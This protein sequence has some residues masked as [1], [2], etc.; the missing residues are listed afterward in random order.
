MS[1]DWNFGD[2]V[3]NI[4]IMF[5]PKRQIFI[6]TP[7][8]TTKTAFLLPNYQQRHNVYLLIV[9]YPSLIHYLLT[10]SCG[11]GQLSFFS[12]F[13]PNIFGP[14]IS[15]N[16]TARFQAEIAEFFKS[17]EEKVCFAYGSSITAREIGKRFS[18]SHSP[19]NCLPHSPPEVYR[20]CVEVKTKYTQQSK[21]SKIS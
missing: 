17:I 19:C 4:C 10:N 3:S 11:T 13:Y 21:P 16:F 8:F 5:Y 6:V 12:S 18:S 20:S 1:C 7:M 9:S 15:F 2:D 14:F